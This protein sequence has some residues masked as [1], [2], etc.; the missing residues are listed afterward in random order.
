MWGTEK[1]GN[2]KIRVGRQSGGMVRGCLQRKY[3]QFFA[4]GKARQM[5]GAMAKARGRLSQAVILLAGN[6]LDKGQGREE[7]DAERDAE[8]SA[9]SYLHSILFITSFPPSDKQF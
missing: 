6:Y 9:A 7:C 5:T 4:N 8:K 1:I 3:V 2:V